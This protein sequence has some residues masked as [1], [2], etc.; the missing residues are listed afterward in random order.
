[1]DLW[2]LG[3]IT[4]I[5]SFPR[6]CVTG[7]L[8]GYP[9]FPQSNDFAALRLIVSGA[10]Q[11]HE[12]QWSAVSEEAKEFIAALLVPNPHH[13]A[14][15]KQACSMRWMQFESK[16]TMHMNS[17]V[18][19]LAR[20]NARRKDRAPCVATLAAVEQCRGTQFVSLVN[21]GVRDNPSLARGMTSR[22]PARSEVRKK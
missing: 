22:I 12:A 5:L 6:G 20:F 4:Y 21:C 8:C 3:V 10:F 1:M 7:R 14:T 19:Q 17:A 16:R 15:A 2:S 18:Q 9:P 13:R 11:F